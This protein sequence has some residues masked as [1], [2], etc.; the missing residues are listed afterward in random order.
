MVNRSVLAGIITIIVFISG[1]SVGMLW[2]S[3]RAEKLQGT[4]EELSIYST[5]IF[6]E[7]QLIKH[8][9]CN[10]FLPVLKGAIGDLNDALD[11]YNRY[12]DA[13]LF[14]IDSKRTLYR[15]YLLSNIRYWRLVEDY[16]TTCNWNSSTILYFFGRDCGDTC[17]GMS[18]KLD[19]L[20]RKYGGD[21]L[22][23]PINLDLSKDDPLAKTLVRVYNA[24]KLP[25]L[26]IDGKKYHNIPLD[27]LEGVVCK[28]LIC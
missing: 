3:F 12:E 27:E 6:L 20:K 16:K 8:T 28:N 21:L 9:D 1:F 22:I 24:T 15:K 14:E 13:S 23:F 5:S 17:G 4:L 2:D 26:I 25:T 19:Y 11:E 7:S 18:T 10:S